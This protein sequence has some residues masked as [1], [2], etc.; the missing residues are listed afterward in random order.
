VDR[1][2]DPGEPN[3]DNLYELSAAEVAERGIVSM[4][5]TLLHACEK[6]TADA[7][8][9]EGLGKVRGGDYIDYFAKVKR[10][11]FAEY[12]AVVSEWETDRYL[13]LF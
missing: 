6:L 13:T 3:T 8:L 12:H 7:V 2:L 5:P 9:R 10:A 11:E 4:P 1:E